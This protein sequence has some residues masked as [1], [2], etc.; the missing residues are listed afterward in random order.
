M[1]VG[2]RVSGGMWVCMWVHVGENY[3]VYTIA[4]RYCNLHQ[5]YSNI[6]IM[7]V[8][9]ISGCPHTRVSTALYHL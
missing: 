9:S 4:L 6:F 3:N 5:Y 2:E 7:Q 1:F 8:G